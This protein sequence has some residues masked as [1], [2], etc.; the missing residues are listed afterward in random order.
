MCVMLSEQ[1]TW[2]D[3]RKQYSSYGGKDAANVN[4]NDQ[5]QAQV[6]QAWACEWDLKDTKDWAEE[7]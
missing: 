5:I 7:F 4:V 3:L 6:L 2:S 1:W